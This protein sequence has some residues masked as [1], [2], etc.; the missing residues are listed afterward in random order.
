MRGSRDERRCVRTALVGAEVWISQN[1]KFGPS[2]LAISA[3]RTYAHAYPKIA[4]IA[5]IAVENVRS[6]YG[7]QRACGERL[8]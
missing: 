4:D 2:T 8:R 1:V 6:S 3:W 7:N 5:P